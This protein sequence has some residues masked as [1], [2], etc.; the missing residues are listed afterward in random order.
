MIDQ[1]KRV[2]LKVKNTA[3]FILVLLAIFCASI[4][5]RLPHFL[6]NDFFFDGDEGILGIMAQDF[7]LGKGLPL[8]F[9]GQNYGFSSLEVVSTAFF[10]KL[11][12]SGIWALRLGGLLLFSI[13][14]TFVWK[15]LVE[16]NTSKII[17]VFCLTLLLLSPTWFLWGG[18]VRGGYV[19][20]FMCFGILFYI[21]LL[22]KMNWKWVMIS[23]L[24]SVVAYESQPLLF[25]PILPFL[26]NWMI[27]IKVNFK[28]LIVFIFLSALLIVTL[29]YFGANETVWSA[30]KSV[31]F[32]AEQFEN[33]AIQSEGMIY[34]YSNFFFFT[35]NIP[36][37]TW[38]FVLLL[39]SLVL[40]VLYILQFYLKSHKQ[41]R[42][43]VL[44]MVVCLLLSVFL[45]SSV[46]L[47]SPR[48]W[49]GFFTGILF[50]FIYAV[51][52][53]DDMKNRFSVLVGLIFIYTLGLISAREMKRDWYF[54]NVNEVNTITELYH[55]VKSRKI[56]AVFIT[57]PVLQWKWNYLFGRSI[58]GTY[59]SEKERTNEF[60]YMVFHELDE[61]PS[62]TAIIG[63]F[64]NYSG[65][66]ESASFKAKIDQV[67]IKYYIM[68]EVEKSLVNDAMVRLK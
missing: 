39:I 62:N 4:L 25:I 16:T 31:F 49:L 58:P 9:Y 66:D 24:I 11:I 20:A 53:G 14:L 26:I 57:D 40:L 10:I 34:G 51:I 42:R 55:E 41:H 37:S 35:M 67:A 61:N 30:P 46:S 45:I 27:P 15:A 50:L 65:F 36:I 12:G 63:L 2:K 44:L 21:T 28:K 52:H 6:S 17:S 7:L 23:S 29:H 47:Y 22:K 32:D 3:S 60:R 1:E 13:G 48:Y 5:V 56:K 38:W 33:L 19:T 43:V 64:G 18:M 59:F 8:Y 54:V 68:D